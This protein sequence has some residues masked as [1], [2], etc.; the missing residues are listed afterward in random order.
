ML[1]AIEARLGKQAS[2][3]QQ[4]AAALG[5]AW[6][7]SIVSTF[8]GATTQLHGSPCCLPGP[9]CSLLP[10]ELSLTRDYASG[11]MQL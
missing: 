7:P 2:E 5:I 11:Q 4:G 9:P 6:K 1:C 8:A 3:Q 10:A